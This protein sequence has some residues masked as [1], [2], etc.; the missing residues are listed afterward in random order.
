MLSM[1]NNKEPTIGDIVYCD[2]TRTDKIK[3]VLQPFHGYVES[4]SKSYYTVIL[5]TSVCYEDHRV[6][7]SSL[8][9]I[10][11]PPAWFHDGSTIIVAES[12][13]VDSNE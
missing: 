8:K 6:V 10:N 5:F 9:S 11:I 2:R 3:P 12:K 1:Y 7:I 13:V 4:C